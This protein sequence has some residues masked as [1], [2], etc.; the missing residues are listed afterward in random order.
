MRQ[1]PRS[2]TLRAERMRAFLRGLVRERGPD[3]G[4]DID[5]LKTRSRGGQAERL[6]GLLEDGGVAADQTT[7]LTARDTDD[8][9]VYFMV[10]ISEV[11][12]TD[13]VA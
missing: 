13:V 2:E 1:T 11:G 7:A 4:R 10:G 6:L 8:V 12:G 5:H 9:L 3:T